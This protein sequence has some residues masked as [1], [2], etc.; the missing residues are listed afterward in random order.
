MIVLKYLLQN[1][2]HPTADQIYTDLQKVIPTL[3][4][5]TVY[6]TLR[7]LSGTGVVRI[8]SI[9]DNELRF[10]IDSKDHG[11]FKCV[12]C[13]NIYDFAADLDILYSKDLFGFTINEKNIYFK[14]ICPNCKMI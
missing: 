11:H 8:I 13:G 3:S 12:A 1:R 2:T 10:D 14:G 5:T 7:I 6:N 9:D 4:K